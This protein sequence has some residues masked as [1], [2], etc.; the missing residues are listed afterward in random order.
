MGGL[1]LRLGRIE[2][3][4]AALTQY[5]HDARHAEFGRLLNDEV[6]S[7]AARHTLHE[8]DRERRFA[9]GV[10]GDADGCLA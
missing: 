3:D 10:G 8:R 6:H 2:P 5:R 4:D 1:G 7:I 9:V